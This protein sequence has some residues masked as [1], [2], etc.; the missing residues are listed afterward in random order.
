VFREIRR[1][2]RLSPQE[3]W[4]EQDQKNPYQTLKGSNR[5]AFNSRYSLDQ[6]IQ[7]TDLKIKKME[8]EASQACQ[9]CWSLKI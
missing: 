7:K 5:K 8:T 6:V 1:V 9:F 2:L 3:G 4:N